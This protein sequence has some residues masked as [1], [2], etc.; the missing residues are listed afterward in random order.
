[1]RAISVI[2]FLFSAC[3]ATGQEVDKPEYI[4]R[5]IYFG[6]GS[7]AVDSLQRADLRHFMDSVPDIHLYDISIHS[8][9]DNIGGAAYNKW[10]SQ[11][12]SNA[13]IDEL[14]Q[15]RI[16]P[17][18]IV[19]KDFGQINPLYDNSTYEGRRLNRRVDIV[20]WPIVF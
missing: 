2:M 12:R 17:K 10:L 20:F 13:V 14:I 16:D 11:M 3:C 8:H 18:S 7:Y 1:M 5:S 6:G 4:L 15:L 9:T 19:I